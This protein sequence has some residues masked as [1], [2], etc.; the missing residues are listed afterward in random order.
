MNTE[1]KLPEVVPH[2]PSLH[3]SIIH[4]ISD[5]M[6]NKSSWLFGIADCGIHNNRSSQNIVRKNAKMIECIV[7]E[8]G[9]LLDLV[10]SLM[11]IN[12]HSPLHS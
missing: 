11:K 8:L 4:V 6:E 9:G 12:I 3:C 1:E 5:N 10:N 7:C 2:K